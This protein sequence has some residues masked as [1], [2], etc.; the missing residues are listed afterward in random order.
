[1]RLQLTLLALVPAA[2]WALL[3][4]PV[5]HARHTIAFGPHI[6]AIHSSSVHGNA[7]SPL[8]SFYLAPDGLSKSPEQAGEEVAAAF[9]RHLHRAGTFRLQSGYLS[10]HNGVYHAHYVVS[11]SLLDSDRGL[12]LR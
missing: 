7:D 11:R 1:M 10:E 3:V 12:S 8:T 2:T 6:E 4:N 9:V 5:H